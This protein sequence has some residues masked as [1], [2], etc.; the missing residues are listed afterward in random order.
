MKSSVSI[1]K[2]GNYDWQQVKVS[3][4]K[5]LGLLGGIE[6]FIRPGSRVLVKPNLLMAKE[7]E[8]AITTHPQILRAVIVLLKEIGCKVIVGDGPS[9]WGNQIEDVGQVYCVSGTAQ[10]CKEES[11]ELVEFS[12]RRMRDKFPLTTYLDECDFLVNLP[13]LKTH[14]FTLVSAAVKNLFGLVCGTYKTELH[15]NYFDAR[16]FSKI[17]AEILKEV[18]PALTIVDGVV[19]LEGDGPAT[20]G[21]PKQLGLILAGADCVALDSLV[22]K[23]IGIEPR[24]VL[25]TKEAAAMGLGVSDLGSIR[26][27]G[28]DLNSVVESS[29][30][31]KSVV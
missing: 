16:D 28:E 18:R 3:V 9:V 30:D 1:V 12:K 14:E 25:S 15:K 24:D 27:L 7:P 19:A 21:R 2:C 4:K 11:V 26:I 6:S 31:R 13:K 23:I 10:V 5:A 17:L 20:S 29:L 22:A 8:A